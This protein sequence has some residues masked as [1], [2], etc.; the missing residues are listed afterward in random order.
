VSGLKR[1]VAII[2]KWGSF[3]KVR[4]G[5]IIAV[6]GEEV[7]WEV[8]PVELSTIVFTVNAGISS[9]VIRLANEYGVDVVFL[10]GNYPMARLLN[11]KYGGSL[12]VWTSQLREFKKPHYL[13]RKIVEGK[14]HNQYIVL[15][16]YQRKYEFSFLDEPVFTLMDYESKAK[17]AKTREE[18]R[19][20]EAH[21]AKHY[22]KGVSNLLPKW[23]N[24]RGRE[25]RGAKDA[26]NLSLNIGYS[27]L[28]VIAWK[29]VVIAGLNP[30]L[31]FLHSFRNGRPSLVFDIMEEF[32]A[33][34]V[35]R[36]LIVAFRE[37]KIIDGLMKYLEDLKRERREID[38]TP[39]KEVWKTVM[40]SIKE[41]EV[42]TQA[43]RLANYLIGTEEEYKP[44]K[45]AS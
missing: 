5:M 33:P 10:K 27:V 39:L 29:A 6:K 12:R 38:R 41:E 8:S 42:I 45:V 31:G 28:K 17:S 2:D 25:K 21:A 13:A 26:F 30:Y 37:G 34:F 14:V 44:F 15:R 18:A 23:V 20:L 24:F 3:V 9:E 36:P 11:Y 16:Y 35:D 7:L 22:W 43:R 1:K 19:E 4:N 32:R 40:N